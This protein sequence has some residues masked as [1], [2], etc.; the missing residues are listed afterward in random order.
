M[1]PS[2]DPAAVINIP[3]FWATWQFWLGVTGVYYAAAGYWL[4]R[5]V[6]TDAWWAR[7]DGIQEGPDKLVPFFMWAVSP[8][9][10]AAVVASVPLWVVSGG[11]I[12]P[13][14]RW[15]NA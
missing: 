11:L 14:W 8:V 12:Q 4:R 2:E 3:A 1:T 6:Y 13:A 5:M 15:R 10:A 9:I 7:A